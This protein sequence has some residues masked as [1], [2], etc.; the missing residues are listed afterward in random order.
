MKYSHHQTKYIWKLVVLRTYQ[1]PSATK[2]L[3]VVVTKLNITI[4]LCLPAHVCYMLPLR[5]IEPLSAVRSITEILS[6]KV[7]FNTKLDHIL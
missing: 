6:T 5:D 3:Y 1:H 4:H 2:S 7:L